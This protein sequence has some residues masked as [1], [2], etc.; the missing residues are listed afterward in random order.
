MTIADTTRRAGPFAANGV[1]TEFP[2]AFK[3][4]TEDDVVV[5]LSDG[6]AADYT[7]D[8]NAAQDDDPGGTVVFGTTPDDV[9]VTITSAVGYEQPSTYTNNGFWPSV[10]NASLDRLT[11]LAQQLRELLGR[12]P[13]FPAGV[14]PHNFSA[15]GTAGQIPFVLANGDLGFTDAE[16]GGTVT[17]WGG[18]LGT[19][20]NQT[21]LS[22]ALGL[23]ANLSII[24]TGGTT[25]QV[26]AKAS[27]TNY[28][29]EWADPITGGG[30]GGVTSVN[31]SG[32]T[33]GLAFTGGPITG[34]GTLTLTGTLA[35]ANGGTGATT[36]AAART[37]L[38][39]VPAGAILDFA[40]STAPTG[41]LECNGAAVSRVTYADLFAAIGTT[42]GAGNGSTTFNLPPQQGYFRRSWD[43]GAG[44][45]T[46][47]AFASFQDSQLGAHTHGYYRPIN[48][49]SGAPGGS[50]GTS[51][52]STS[53]SAGG[54]SNT[55]E[56][57]PASYAYLTCIKT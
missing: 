13:A 26:L 20:S 32:G 9:D 48:G 17:Q 33:T 18:I 36:A 19:L 52:F 49:G 50:G 54:T 28:A 43:N 5:T 3:V 29:F 37:A 10:L 2:F 45:D 16:A 27:G 57:R 40:M 15:R 47:R 6:S 22:T 41:W 42:W 12:A 1:Q 24:P 35:I 25:G 46:G 14:T 34:S 4:F 11:I 30:E 38:G 44:V 31:G 51:T 8:L 53:F 7:V 23:K 55:S 39:G 21:D 56:T